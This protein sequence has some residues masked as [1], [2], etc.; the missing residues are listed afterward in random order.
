MSAAE[1]TWPTNTGAG[2]PPGSNVNA[3]AA[4]SD[5]MIT[6][7]RGLAGLSDV[8]DNGKSDTWNTCELFLNAVTELSDVAGASLTELMMMSNVL[9]AEFSTPPLAVPPS[10]WACTVMVAVPL[11]FAAAV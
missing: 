2:P 10:S 6:L 7:S 11:A 1:I 3:P 5:V 9:S 4:G 8:S